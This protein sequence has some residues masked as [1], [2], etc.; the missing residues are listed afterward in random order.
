MNKVPLTFSFEED[1]LEAME[2]ISETLPV[3]IP[4][5]LPS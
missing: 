5:L 4:L 2:E 1:K 3:S